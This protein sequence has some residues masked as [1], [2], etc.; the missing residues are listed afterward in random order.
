LV[1]DRK[2]HRSMPN[3]HREAFRSNGQCQISNG[4]WKMFLLLLL[5][6]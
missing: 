2:S 5:N 1:I 4:K 6:L 3:E